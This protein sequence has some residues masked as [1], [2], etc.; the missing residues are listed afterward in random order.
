MTQKEHFHYLTSQGSGDTSSAKGARAIILDWNITKQFDSIANR[1][2][3]ALGALEKK[4]LLKLLPL[5]NE[6]DYIISSLSALEPEIRPS[7]TS[8]NWGRYSS[9]SSKVCHLIENHYTPLCNALRSGRLW[10]PPALAGHAEK[11]LK[12]A[13]I[14]R[15]DYIEPSCATLLKGITLAHLNDVEPLDALAEFGHWI[16]KELRIFCGRQAL[17][18]AVML[19]GKPQWRQHVRTIL[20]ADRK[21][22]QK[23][24]VKWVWGAAWDLTYALFGDMFEPDGPFGTMFFPWA[25]ASSDQALVSF[26]DKI[27][28]AGYAYKRI[29]CPI[30][31][32][33]CNLNNFFPKDATDDVMSFLNDR[34]AR[35]ARRQ[36]LRRK[37]SQ[38]SSG[39]RRAR[40]NRVRR[41][42]ELETQRLINTPL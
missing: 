9:R 11:N 5:L 42:L 28:P 26:V 30:G 36:E 14:L 16:D 33:A 8:I 31:L 24:R 6:A 34:G 12:G 35:V 39:Q 13:N 27:N 32:L 38:Y 15:E 22:S 4:R 18:I 20:K 3:E 23:D 10:I 19:L 40:A 1:G 25:F 37:S 29:N 2:T 41:I 21:G 17:M 7:R